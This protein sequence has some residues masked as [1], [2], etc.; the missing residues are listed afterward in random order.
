M[1]LPEFLLAEASAAMAANVIE[2]ANLPCLVTENDQ[3]FI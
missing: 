2:D 3:T 1:Q